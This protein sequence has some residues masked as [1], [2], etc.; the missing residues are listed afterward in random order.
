MAFGMDAKARF[1]LPPDG[2]VQLM[3]YGEFPH[4]GAG[5]IQV[6]DR[7]AADSI[8]EAFRNRVSGGQDSPGVAIDFDHYSDLTAEERDALEKIGVALPSEAAGWMKDIQARED[9]IYIRADWTPTGLE[10]ITG[11]EYRFLSPCFP[12][13]DLERLGDGKVR[14]TSISK[15][16]LTNEPNLVGIAALTNRKGGSGLIGPACQ[17]ENRAINNQSV[18]N[19]EK[20]MDYKG[21]LCEMLGIPAESDDAAIENACG[22]E[23]KRRED[24]ANQAKD[25]QAEADMA[26]LEKDGM[27]FENR[28][29][30]KA[31][32]LTNRDATLKALRA[33]KPKQV[34]LPNRADG[35]TPEVEAK[36]EKVKAREAAL[37][38]AA[39]EN[40]CVTRSQAWEIAAR[41]N[42]EL[43]A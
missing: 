22:A 39:L 3:P 11:G 32:L 10:K 12:I 38:K 30:V 18:N 25:A 43:F 35:K 42:P 36:E 2:F 16:G 37:E 28:A 27:S 19:Q 9:G 7:K 13:A 34:T 5:L 33:L 29:D 21:K 41:K 20:R 24:V 15:A 26:E 8:V 4:K 6:L 31:G 17:L 1:E 23:M 40:R 14:P